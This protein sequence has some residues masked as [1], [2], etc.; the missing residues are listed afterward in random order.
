MFSKTLNAEPIQRQPCPWL[1][2][3]CSG[4]KIAFT[5]ALSFLCLALTY[6]VLVLTYYAFVCH[7]YGLR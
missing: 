2:S 7:K 3:L 4:K 1:L 6:Y 5:S